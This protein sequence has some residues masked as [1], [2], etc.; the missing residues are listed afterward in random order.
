MYFAKGRIEFSAYVT[1]I[2]YIALKSQNNHI[3]Y[4][5]C[6]ELN[7]CG[8][9]YVEFSPSLL[10]LIQKAMADFQTFLQVF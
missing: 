2:L 6:C 1:D 8:Y 4:S 9:H 7:T 5:I 10:G 3:V